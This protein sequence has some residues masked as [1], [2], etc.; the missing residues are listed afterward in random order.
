[1]YDKTVANNHTFV[2]LCKSE[3]FLRICREKLFVKP[4]AN[5]IYNTIYTKL[6]GPTHVII[7]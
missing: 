5:K 2:V 4:N 1:M 3:I 7:Y 6:C